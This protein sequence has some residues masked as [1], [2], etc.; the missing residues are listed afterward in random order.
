VHV[1]DSRGMAGIYGAF[2][3]MC[4]CNHTT[5]AMAGNREAV[6]NAMI[7]LQDTMGGESIL[8]SMPIQRN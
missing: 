5:W 1:M 6:A 3:A 7:S 8:G 2:A 4:D